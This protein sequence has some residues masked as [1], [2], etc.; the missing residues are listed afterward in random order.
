MRIPVVSPY[1]IISVGVV[2]YFA[3]VARF[4][5]P[6]H[7]RQIHSFDGKR[8][9]RA[10]CYFKVFAYPCFRRP[11]AGLG[12][13][14][15]RQGAGY[16]VRTVCNGYGFMFGNTVVNVLAH[17]PIY[18]NLFGFYNIFEIG[19]AVGYKVVAVGNDKRVISPC[20]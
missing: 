16:S 14:V 8:T 1:E 5:V 10:A 15:H 9:G 6:R 13:S 3:D 12:I 20:V 18:G 2:P 11:F 7:A 4:K 19:V 17:R